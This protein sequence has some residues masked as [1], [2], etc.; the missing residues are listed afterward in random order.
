MAFSQCRL[1]LPVSGKFSKKQK[2]AFVMAIKESVEVQ[3]ISIQCPLCYGE[4]SQK[5]FS[6]PS[7]RKIVVDTCI[8]YK[9][10]MRVVGQLNYCPL[11]GVRLSG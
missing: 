3:E 6:C 5:A 11:C 7:C 4:S 10:G 1:N 2:G 9:D 8:G